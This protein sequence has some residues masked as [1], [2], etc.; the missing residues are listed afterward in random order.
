MKKFEIC[1]CGKESP[2]GLPLKDLKKFIEDHRASCH[3]GHLEWLCKDC[4]TTVPRSNIMVHTREDYWVHLCPSDKEFIS[5]VEKAIFLTYHFPDRNAVQRRFGEAARDARKK[6][7]EFYGKVTEMLQL[8]F[9][10]GN[11][12]R[13]IQRAAAAAAEYYARTGEQSLEWSGAYERA[14]RSSNPTNVFWDALCMSVIDRLLE[15]ELS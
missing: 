9:R 13:R 12:Y 15:W 7:R 14:R 1:V 8:G 2:E 5:P 6:A 10:T 3:V 11:C 4:G